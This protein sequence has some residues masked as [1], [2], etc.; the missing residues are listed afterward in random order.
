MHRPPSL[1]TALVAPIAWAL[2]FLLSYCTVAIACAKLPTLAAAQFAVAIYTLMA[3][4]VIARAAAK[5]WPREGLAFESAEPSNR[6]FLQGLTQLLAG[7]SALGT[8]AVALP[9]LMFMDCR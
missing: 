2:H 3:L 5:A 7:L 1:W 8:F 4:A 9:L 6:L